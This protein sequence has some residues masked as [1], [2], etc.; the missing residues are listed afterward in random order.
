MSTHIVDDER[1]TDAEWVKF[2]AT[3]VT[4]GDRCACGRLIFGTGC[5]C[6]ICDPE[7]LPLF[8]R[9]CA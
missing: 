7:S 2:M 6:E 3:D 4:P 1:L 9:K 8:L 5:A